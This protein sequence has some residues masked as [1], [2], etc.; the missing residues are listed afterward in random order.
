VQV[1]RDRSWLFGG[2]AVLLCGLYV[3]VMRLTAPTKP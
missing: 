3:L 1:L 2:F